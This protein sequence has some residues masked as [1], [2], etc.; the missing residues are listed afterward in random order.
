[1]CVSVC[2]GGG[3]VCMYIHVC[4]CVSEG[5]KYACVGG[6]VCMH[7][8]MCVCVGGGKYACMCVWG[9]SHGAFLHRSNRLFTTF[10]L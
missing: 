10:C 8:I 1:M 2:V 5:G 3:A 7:N 9:G 4:V 6:A